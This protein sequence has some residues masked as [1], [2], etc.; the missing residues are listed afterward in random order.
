MLLRPVLIGERWASPLNSAAAWP[1]SA[2]APSTGEIFSRTQ[3]KPASSTI[4]WKTTIPNQPSTTSKSVTTTFTISNFDVSCGALRPGR[5]APSL[6]QFLRGAL[7]HESPQ[8]VYDAAGRRRLD[9]VL[10]CRRA[11]AISRLEA[12]IQWQGS[13]RLETRRPRQHDC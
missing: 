10:H 11:A 5:N 3:R 2:R 12:A 8:M 6:A 1:T 9:P 7:R 13:H 4:S